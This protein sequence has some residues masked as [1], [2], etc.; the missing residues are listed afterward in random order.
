MENFWDQERHVAT[1]RYFIVDA[2]TS[3]V[4]LHAS[5]M[6]GYTRENLEQM[7]SEVGF[8]DVVF[9]ESLSGG[10]K[11]LDENLEVIEA[12]R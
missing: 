10:D 6:V 12:R 4:T 8:R 1:T 3:D 7:L 2:E 5:S 9:Y 11:D